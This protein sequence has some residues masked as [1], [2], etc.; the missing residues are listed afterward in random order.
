MPQAL[1][2]FLNLRQYKPRL[3]NG[4]QKPHLF[5]HLWHNETAM[6]HLKTLEILNDYNENQKILLKLP[7]WFVSRWNR[8][9]MEARRKIK[10]DYPRFKEFVDFLSKEADLACNL[11]S[12]IQTL[13]GVESTKP[14]Q[15]RNQPIQAKTLYTNT[16]QSHTSTCPFCRRTGHDLAKC[17]RFG[18]K[19]LQDFVKF[20]RTEKLCFGCL[21]AGAHFD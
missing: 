11:I 3:C 6:P 16:T 4:H 10:P 19:T 9:V 17:T 14:K 18:E 15:L 21:Q 13:K 20:V 7:D 8:E 12:S 2:S 5:W 1:N